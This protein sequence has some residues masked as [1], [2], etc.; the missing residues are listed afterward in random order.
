MIYAG[1]GARS[2]PESV[3]AKM[4]DIGRRGAEAGHTLRTGGA[5]GA[6]AAFQEGA[7][8]AGGDGL[9]WG[10]IEVYRASDA[11]PQAIELASKYHPN[12]RACADYVR[13]LHGR[14]IMILLGHDL[15]SPVDL[16]ICWTP[17]GE[18]VGGTGQA[19]RAAKARGIKVV[20]LGKEKR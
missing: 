16:V 4:R 5:R 3:L 10:F 8:S 20:N 15:N 18:V 17:G 12:W 14:N 7:R 11:T 9:Y 2:T 13:K 1:I 19:L 6:D